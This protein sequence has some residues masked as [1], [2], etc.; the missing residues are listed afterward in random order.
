ML[1]FGI[2]D[3]MKKDTSL[4]VEAIKIKEVDVA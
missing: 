2:H 3:R 4:V 1:L